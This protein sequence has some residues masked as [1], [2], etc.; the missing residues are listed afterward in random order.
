MAP[1]TA[2][3]RSGTGLPNAA[4]AMPLVLLQL[5]QMFAVPVLLRHSQLWGLLLI[6]LALMSGMLWALIHEAI[7]H[8]YHPQGTA[9]DRWG[10]FLSVLFG[11]AFDVVKFG[12]LM[13][14]R[15]NRA[16]E[17]EYYHAHE[18]SYARA[19]LEYYAKLC[20]G[21]YYIS[22]GVTILFMLL[23][24][25]LMQ[26]LF[27]RRID[28]M[29]GLEGLEE[30]AHNFF[31]SRGRHWRVRV[32]GLC[33]LALY[34]VS[35]WAYG[36]F[37][38]SFLFMVAARAFC[39]SF[40]DNIYHYATPADNSVPAK[41]VILP[42]WARGLLLNGNHHLTHHRQAHLQWRNLAHTH[43]EERYRQSFWQ[44]ARDQWRGPIPYETTR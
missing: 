42:S 22:V 18:K 16:W 35:A 39:I 44:A 23:P 11:S 19:A 12:H 4:I 29:P 25:R 13:H 40:M 9:N 8:I 7:H 34:G 31:F 20:G 10:R 38:P 3:T 41:E 6:P 24:L 15:Y 33:V 43:A 26:A 28:A 36:A 37:W 1:S 30:I 2:E 32:D 27:Q 14:H 5:L 21:I 17:S